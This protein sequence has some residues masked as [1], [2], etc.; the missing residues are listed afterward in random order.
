MVRVECTFGVV[1]SALR[2]RDE[3]FHKDKQQS[4]ALGYLGGDARLGSLVIHC[5]VL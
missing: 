4:V 3:G 5:I 1:V 2:I